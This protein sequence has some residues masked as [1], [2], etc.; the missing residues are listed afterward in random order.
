MRAILVLVQP[1]PSTACEASHVG[2]A[3]LRRMLCSAQTFS[4]A[5]P[6]TLCMVKAVPRVPRVTI[7]RTWFS[8]HLTWSGQ[9]NAQNSEAWNERTQ[10]DHAESGSPPCIGVRRHGASDVLSRVEVG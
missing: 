8:V 5:P 10:R 7:L 3:D 9:H 4:S 1:P 6:M 2:T